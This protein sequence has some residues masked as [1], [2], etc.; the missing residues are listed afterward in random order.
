[1]NTTGLEKFAQASR[2]W[3]VDAVAS[4]MEA[5]L[6]QG[7]R[8]RTDSKRLVESL[9]KEIADEAVKDS[10]K[11]RDHVAER[12]AYRWFNRIIAFRY[13]DVHGFTDVHVVS[14]QIASNVEGL[15]EVLDRALAGDLA[16]EPLLGGGAEQLKDSIEQVLRSGAIDAQ[17][18]AYGL[19]LQSQCQRWNSVM[20]FMFDGADDVDRLLLPSGLLSADS[21]VRMAM[22][23]MTPEVCGVGSDGGSV[24]VIGW[25]YQ[26]YISE[27]KNQ[28]MDGFKHGLKAGKDE[29]PAATQLFTPEWIVEY[30]VQNTLGREWAEAH[31]DTRLTDKWAY[32]VHS[33][34]DDDAMNASDE[35]SAIDTALDPAN[36]TVCDPA[37]GS[38]HM[39]TY[40][41][42]VLM[43]IYLEA[44]YLS[45]EAAHRILENNLFGLEIDSRAANLASFALTMKAR[46]YD[47]KFFQAPVE[48][49]I[50]AVETV[51]FGP[52]DITELNEM[53]G[54]ALDESEWNVFAHADVY[55]SLIK[56]SKRL[57]EL[58]KRE[59]DAE[60]V[61][62]KGQM[63][64]F[65]QNAV[66][67]AQVVFKQARMLSRQYSAVVANPPY[68]GSKNMSAP[69]KQYLEKNYKDGKADLFAAFIMRCSGM[70]ASD[71]RTGM[72]TMQSWMFLKSFLDL[73]KKIIATSVIES[74]AHLG[75]G[76]FDSI[77]GEV[78][79]TTAFVLKQSIPD[80]DSKGVY[81]RLLDVTG[82]AAMSSAFISALD[83]DSGNRYLSKQSD[84]KDIPGSPI[85]YWLS[86]NMRRVFQNNKKLN[87]VASPRQGLATG[88]NNRFL[89]YWFETSNNRINSCAV[90]REEAT[91]SKKKWFPL[92]KGG[93]FRRWYGNHEY[94]VNWENDGCSIRNFVDLRGRQKSRPQNMDYFFKEGIT[95]SAVTTSD[96]SVR[97]S[98]S[99]FISNA[100]GPAIY[101]SSDCLKYLLG[102]I[103]SSV[104][105]TLLNVLAP[106]LDYSQGPMGNLPLPKD[107]NNAY[108]AISDVTE[109]LISTS[110]ADWDS[111]ETSWDF[112]RSPLL[113]FASTGSLEQAVASLIS[114]WKAL[115]EEQR[116][117][118][119][120]NNELVADAYGV[121]DGVECDVPIE[122]VS[123]KRNPAF[124]YPGKTPK[125]RDAAVEQDTVKE[126]ISYAVGC[127]FG[128]YSLDRPGLIL[129]SQGQTIDDYNVAVP[130]RTF[131]PDEDGVIPV[132]PDD[133]FAD[134]IVTYF[135]AFLG[136]SFGE[137]TVDQNV[138]YV[139]TTLGCTLREYFTTKFYEDHLK[140]YSN[141]PI[142]WM[143]S[144]R[145]DNKGTFKALTYLHRYVPYT[146]SKVLDYL[147]DYRNTLISRISMLTG[148]G[149]DSAERQRTSG[150]RPSERKQLETLKSAVQECETYEDDVLYPL[151]TRS[152]AIDL[153]DGV[154]VNYLRLGPALRKI[155]SLEK[156]RKEVETW[157][158]PTYPLK[159]SK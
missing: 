10:T 150:L 157:E 149:M 68:M 159:K 134:D 39:L 51:D 143:W 64:L 19:L 101:G 63:S 36:L 79:S 152:L 78:V 69:L 42:D 74:M 58:A 14:P 107:A 6:A 53:Y 118:E 43:D 128:R 103:N 122:R 153:D 32:Y 77:G 86:D 131:E 115:S 40:A 16:F 136:A 82:E 11:A 151:A 92:Q 41:F 33:P 47:R 23:V 156:K 57:V 30:L 140:M 55:G 81:L 112:E 38:G 17:D 18:T 148:V 104:V 37:C 130:D 123:L 139:E 65:T 21:P 91:N 114:K 4:R 25:L 34:N 125:E 88:D 7:S 137:K 99:G 126:F 83:S 66:G 27:R 26:Y 132:L 12:Y 133:Y 45:R 110:K 111:Y 73:R 44:G 31:P 20:N 70:T 1:M 50:M 72:I 24:E 22:R 67:R 96:I 52:S 120:H 138:K 84:F 13:M 46:A 135:S 155:A 54:V 59:T 35:S 100:K 89:R 98:P 144:S 49:H 48:P 106:T 76:A 3:L 85:V 61:A 97:Y 147:R 109:Q 2:I 9:E 141:R 62:G 8:E 108:S 93:D 80:D 142:Y 146:A 105:Q 119:I 15:P 60:S 154:L 75:A 5:V 129:A 87:S 158:W 28:V 90:S 95:W 71:G 56:P 121:R 117:R 29:I 145:T 116:Q 124:A 94:L 127:M 113:E 102:T